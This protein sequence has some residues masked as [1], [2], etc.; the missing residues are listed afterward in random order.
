MANVSFY[1]TTGVTGTTGNLWAM[2]STLSEWSTT[3][4]YGS[5]AYSSISGSNYQWLYKVW[6]VAVSAL[7]NQGYGVIVEPG[8]DTNEILYISSVA[9]VYEIRVG[10]YN[11]Y[12][13]GVRIFFVDGAGNAIQLTIQHSSQTSSTL[14][15]TLS[16]SGTFY[17]KAVRGLVY[18]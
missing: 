4:D 16:S 5:F 12:Y 8:T 18:N 9:K 1:S 3:T 17:V 6:R 2:Y 7:N 13:Y 11:E 10:G 15:T 14:S